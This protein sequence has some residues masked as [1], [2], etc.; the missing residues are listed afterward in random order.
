MQIRSNKL[1]NDAKVLLYA[2]DGSRRS[3]LLL[4]FPSSS[5]SIPTPRSLWN[6]IA[7]LLVISTIRIHKHIEIRFHR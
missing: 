5:S 4:I 2:R 3:Q 6:W 1:K 7:I